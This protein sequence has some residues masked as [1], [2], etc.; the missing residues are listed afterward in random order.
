EQQRLRFE[1][2]Y[3]NNRISNTQQISRIDWIESLY[4]KSLDDFRKYCSWCIFT[5]Y[6]INVRKL[7]RSDVF[8]LIMMST[9]RF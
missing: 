1:R 5:P 3:A 6:F 4:A 9:S 2:K 8:N 7:S